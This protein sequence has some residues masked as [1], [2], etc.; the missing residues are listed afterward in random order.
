MHSRRYIIYFHLR[1][2][3]CSGIMDERF[4]RNTESEEFTMKQ[5]QGF[6]LAELLIVVAIISVLVAISIPILNKQLEKSREA[7]DA[8][9]IRAQYA[10]VMADAVSDGKSVNGKEKYHEVS[11]QQK[12]SLWQDEQTGR[13]LESIFQEVRGVPQAGGSA[14]VE[15]EADIKAVILHYE[16]GTGSSDTPAISYSGS[17]S[18][19]TKEFLKHSYT[20]RNEGSMQDGRAFFSN[21]TF[22]IDGKQV[23]VR[24]YY[25][26][27]ASFKESLAGWTVQPST[28]VQ[29]PF[30]NNEEWHANEKDQSQGFA[31]YT[32]GDNEKINRF[33]YV[34][35]DKVY[36]TRDEGNTWYDITPK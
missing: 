15:Y 29:S 6:T 1:F 33:I 34:N 5:E 13:N 4:Y 8:A 30:Y 11:L 14:W 21:Q 23:T 20:T 25:A 17:L 3:L 16:N 26:D 36:E 22:T 2:H 24:V 7:A 32:Y 12:R 18:D 10:K 19:G 31:Y 28:Y 35:N 27:S 9:N